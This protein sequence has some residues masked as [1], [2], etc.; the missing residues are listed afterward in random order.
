MILSVDDCLVV[1]LPKI[2]DPRGNLTF[3]ENSKHIPFDIKRVF[4][5]YDVPTDAERGAHAHK[6]LHQFLICLSGGLSVS[7][8]DGKR[9]RRVRLKRPWTGLYIPPLLWASE[10]EFDSGTVYMVLA[11]N[12][13]DPGDYIRDYTEFIY[14]ARQDTV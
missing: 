9:K 5:I 10:R 13:Y 8:D 2:L 1:E 4:Y 11:S 7:L 6:T 14:A 3:I 12:F